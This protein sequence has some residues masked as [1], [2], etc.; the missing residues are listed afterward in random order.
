MCAAWALGRQKHHR[1]TLIT[2]DT[3]TL[4]SDRVLYRGVVSAD[5][6]LTEFNLSQ[7]SLVRID[8]ESLTVTPRDQL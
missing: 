6:N 8:V 7:V 5:Y 4:T 2:R 3:R 1:A